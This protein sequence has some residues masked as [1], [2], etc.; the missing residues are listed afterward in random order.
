[1]QE[2]DIGFAFDGDGDRIGVVDEK[3]EIR[4]AD[5]ILLLLAEDHLSRHRGKPIV[6]TVSNSSI[7]E[8]EIAQ[9]NGIPIMCTVGH[10]FV[11]HAMR[12][13][14]ALLGGEQSGHFFF[15]EEYFGF[16]DALMA[17]LRTLS[18]VQKRGKPCS[19]LF[20]E[21]PKV[22]QTPEYRPTCPDEDKAR[23]VEEIKQHFLNKKYPINTLDGARID[24]G[25]SAWAGI[26][27]SNTAPKL[28]VCMEARS[29]K[30]LKEV[31]KEV[32][33]ILKKYPEIQW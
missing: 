20:K 2:L 8:T 31:E 16:D 23:I 3:G 9:W 12:E 6:F 25:D 33:G 28:S 27:K 1:M 30:K 17:A 4:T 11:E 29:P 32:M 15:G 10:S 18:I 7:L 24:F 19:A 5:E 14:G 21:F 13:H 26:R 22:Y